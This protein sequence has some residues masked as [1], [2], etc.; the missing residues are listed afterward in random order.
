MGGYSS[1]FGN[2][3][4]IGAMDASQQQG[5][6]LVIKSTYGNHQQET[7][8]IQSLLSSGVSGIIVQPVQGEIYN[9]LIVQLILDSFPIVLLDRKLQ[10]IAAPFV[11]VDNIAL[12]KEAGQ[13]II[14]QGHRN[15]ALLAMTNQYSSTISDRIQG[16]SEACQDSALPS[17][18]KL[19]LTNISQMIHSC[20]PLL[21]VEEEYEIMVQLLQQHLLKN[22]E[23]TAILAT[24]YRVAKAACEAVMRLGKSIP[25]DISIVGFDN[26]PGCIQT[27]AMSHVEQ[28]QVEMGRTACEVLKQRLSA[29]EAAPTQHLLPG[30]WIQ[31]SSLGPVPNL[32]EGSPSNELSR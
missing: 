3:I 15:I 19:W 29:S 5:L 6:H 11:G 31:G 8:I 1:H 7:E 18:K 9:P 2:D 28:P 27:H 17:D 22:P 14:A 10:G 26:D 4:L 25:K 16:F 12:G 23:I 30:Q 24:E 21:S 13:R 32:C 20:K